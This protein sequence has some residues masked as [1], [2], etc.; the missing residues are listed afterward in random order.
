MGYV[1]APRKGVDIPPSIK[2]HVDTG[3]QVVGEVKTK[4]LQSGLPQDPVLLR[5]FGLE[6]RLGVWTGKDCCH[7][8]KGDGAEQ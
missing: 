1:I 2:A 5:Y 4:Y 8:S 7:I 6:A 3:A